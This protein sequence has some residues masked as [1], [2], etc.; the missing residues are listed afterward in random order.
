MKR[1]ACSSES[2]VKKTL[3]IPVELNTLLAGL[4]SELLICFGI[5]TGPN[6][7][8]D[9][10]KTCIGEW[11]FSFVEPVLKFPCL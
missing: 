4:N 11:I 2:T 9:F 5:F 10:G 8:Q 7:S 6:E 3:E 1:V